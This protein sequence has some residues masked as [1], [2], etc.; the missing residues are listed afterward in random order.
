MITTNEETEIAALA[1][2]ERRF[3]ATFRGQNINTIMADL[4]Q[5]EEELTDCDNCQVFPFA[6]RDSRV[7]SR[8]GWKPEI[9][10]E[11]REYVIRYGRC[12]RWIGANPPQQEKRPT[13]W[14][15]K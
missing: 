7:R 4:P 3:N 6:C 12:S 10:N 11:D 13:G 9:V 5:V 8:W 14:K 2:L 15:A 1:A